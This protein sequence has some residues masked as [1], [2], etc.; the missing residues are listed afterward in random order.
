MSV[1]N[2]LMN[3]LLIALIY[4]FESLYTQGVTVGASIQRFIFSI[5]FL[6]LGLVI[7]LAMN[8]YQAVRVT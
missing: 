5:F 1:S 8:N 7:A 6:V 3:F 4:Q 2:K